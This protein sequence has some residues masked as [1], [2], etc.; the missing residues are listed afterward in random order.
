[1]KTIGEIRAAIERVRT[2]PVTKAREGSLFLHPD[3]EK[4][5]AEIA[6]LKAEISEFSKALKELDTVVNEEI[7]SRF[8]DK[9]RK[10]VGE[11]VVI[12][13][14][15]RKVREFASRDAGLALLHTA[16]EIARLGVD[17]SAIGRY[18]KEHGSLPDGVI[19]EEKFSHYLLKKI[20]E[21]EDD[22]T[23]D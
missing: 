6:S 10:V 13:R 11:Y 22:S 14:V 5:L 1:M 8:D 18:V 3:F 2:T 19:E 17:A 9:T 4:L 21:N 15:F 7:S 16:E 20:Q 12:T 23:D